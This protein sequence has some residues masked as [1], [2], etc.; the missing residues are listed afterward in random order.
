M[1]SFGFAYALIIKKFSLS[2]FICGSV[3]VPLKSFLK[4]RT[5]SLS[6]NFQGSRET[7][8]IYPYKNITWPIQFR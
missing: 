3:G 1:K 8:N 6:L 5:G 4:P 2:F 7:D